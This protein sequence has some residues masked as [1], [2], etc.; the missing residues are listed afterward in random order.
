MRGFLG[1]VF[2]A[3]VAAV[4]LFSHAISL[5]TDLLWFQAVGFSQ[6]FT[7]TIAIK[8]AL[9]T[10]F[11]GLFFLLLYVNLKIAARLPSEDWLLHIQG[12]LDLPSPEVI[13]PLIRRLLLPVTILMG[14]LAAPQ[15]AAQWKTA[16]LFFNSVSFG[17]EDPLFGYDVGFFVFLL[18]AFKSLYNWFLVTLAL[19]SIASAYLYFLYRAI[20]Y[21]EQGLSLAHNART[22]LFVLIASL[23]VVQAGG[24]LLDA[25]ELLFSPRGAAYGASY[26]D[27]YANLPALRILTILSLVAAGLTLFQIYR[28]GF[29]YLF[30]GLGALILVHVLGLYLYPSFL[31]HFLVVPNE[32]DKETPYI[33]RNIQFTRLGYDIDKVEGQEFPAEEQ[34]SAE[35]LRRNDATVKNIRIWDHRPLLAT[36]AQ[37]QQLRTY[38]EFVNVDNDRYL[39]DGN[40][41]QIMISARELSHEQLPSKLWINQ[42]LNFTHGYGVVFGPVNRVTPEGLPEFFIKDIPPVFDGP[43]RV[44]RP[45]IYYGELA[46]DY[47]FVKTKAQELDYPAGDRNI[48]TTYVGQGGVLLKS[49]WR[50]A[51]A[52]VFGP[53]YHPENLSVQRYYQGKPYPLLPSYPGTGQKDCPIPNLRP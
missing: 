31:Q 33:E 25:L 5:Y 11:G 24:Y 19:I 28:P 3:I 22:H 36:Y 27:I 48:Y 30:G 51:Q 44:T 21:S 26:S 6:I 8:A 7:K 17:I 39:I 43:I 45:E 38:Y 10:L 47:V 2:L 23:L 16:L 34:L 52:P 15:A 14:F 29:R 1:L 18:P 12:G 50:K 37:L 40:Y 20:H 49:F 35:D 41:R 4:F 53:L 13:N 32:I 9:G 46:N 42:H